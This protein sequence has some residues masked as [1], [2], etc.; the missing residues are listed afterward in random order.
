[1]KRT[2]KEKLPLYMSLYMWVSLCWSSDIRWHSNENPTA[3]LSSWTDSILS[4]KGHCDHTKK[5]LLV[6][7]HPTLLVTKMSAVTRRM[8]RQSDN[9]SYWKG[10]SSIWHHISYKNLLQ[11]IIP[12]NVTLLS[13]MANFKLCR[14]YRCVWRISFFHWE[15]YTEGWQ[16]IMK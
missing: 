3:K 11:V 13:C 14:L 7:R 9:I 4:V 2:P 12:P 15:S 6:P 8:K 16:S 5:A 10:Q 1:M